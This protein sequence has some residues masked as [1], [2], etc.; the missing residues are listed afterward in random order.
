MPV[1][2][3]AHTTRSYTWTAWKVI[4]SLKGGTPQYEDSNNVYTIWFYDGPEVYICTIWKGTVPDP[5]IASGYT[6]EQNDADE[7][8]FIAN[9]QAKANYPIVPVAVD[10]RQQTVPNLLPDWC[11]LYFTGSGDHSSNGLGE[12]TLFTHESDDTTPTDH[13]VDWYFTSQVYLVGGYVSFID[14]QVGDYLSYSV[15]AEATPLEEGTQQVVLVPYGSGNVIVPYSETGS[16]TIDPANAVPIPASGDGFWDWD[17]PTEGS[18]TITPNYGQT[19][20]CN[21]LDFDLVLGRPAMKLPCLGTGSLEF[22]MPN[23]T[24]FLVLPQWTHRATIHNI[25]HSGLKV[26]WMFTGG[27]GGYV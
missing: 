6:Q 2:F 21:L 1:Q 17:Y 18:G 8:D 19:G 9:Y 7:A 3:V 24:P 27:R 13:T 10:G 16:T 25:G 11:S 5:V 15:I 4:N 14:A 26:S 12:G 20:N 22:M 23:I